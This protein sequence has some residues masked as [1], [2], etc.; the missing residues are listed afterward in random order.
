MADVHRAAREAA[1]R[2]AREGVRGA[3]GR[4]AGRSFLLFTALLVH[5]ARAY[6]LSHLVE[7]L[8]TGAVDMPAAAAAEKEGEPRD[9]V[10][11]SATL[12]ACATT[13]AISMLQKL[14]QPDLDLDAPRVLYD[15]RVGLAACCVPAAGRATCMTELSPAYSLLHYKSQSVGAAKL[16]RID[17][18]H[19]LRITAGAAGELAHEVAGDWVMS[20][21]ELAVLVAAEA[22]EDDAEMCY[23]ALLHD[24]L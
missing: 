17:A 10:P 13:A 4:P 2:H 18:L 9:P 21:S 24:E 12:A 15:M 19:A 14:S 6:P 20:E 11:F 22:C 3:G 8:E 1:R 16:A 7:L 23:A 5:D